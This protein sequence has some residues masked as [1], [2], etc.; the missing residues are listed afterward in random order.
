MVEG[1]YPAATPELAARRKEL[2]PAI[3][4]AFENFGRAVLPK[5]RSR[6]KQSS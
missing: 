5:A 4:D 6:K 2:A 1:M 3:N